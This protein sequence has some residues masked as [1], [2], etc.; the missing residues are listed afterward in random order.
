[1]EGGGSFSYNALTKNVIFLVAQKGN[2]DLLKEIVRFLQ[3]FDRNIILENG[4]K[5]Y[6]GYSGQFNLSVNNNDFIEAVLIP[7]FDSVK[8]YS[9][10][11]LDYEDFKAIL[12]MIQKGFHYIPEG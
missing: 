10:K 3:E 8:W 1:M 9:K 7:L 5:I 2:E 6:P 4:V 12:K 11:Y